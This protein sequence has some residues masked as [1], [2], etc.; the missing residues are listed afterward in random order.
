VAENRSLRPEWR[1]SSR[2]DG[3]QCIEVALLD[4]QI[5][6]RDSTDPAGPILDFDAQTWRAFVVSLRAGE[7]DRR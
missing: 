4:N 3:G 6:M 7:F 2:C 5:A 1:R